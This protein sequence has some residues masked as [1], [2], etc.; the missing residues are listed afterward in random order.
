MAQMPELTTY[1]AI[2]SPS[3]SFREGVGGR[4]RSRASV[5]RSRYLTDIYDLLPRI[6]RSNIAR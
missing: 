4:A 2:R 3:A 1:M 6:H 5:F